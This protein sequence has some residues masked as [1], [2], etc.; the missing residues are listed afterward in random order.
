MLCWYVLAPPVLAQPWWAVPNLLASNH[1]SLR[2][3]RAGPGI[4]TVTGPALLLV[5][6]GIIGAFTGLAAPG[7][8]LVGLAVALAWYIASLRY[9]WTR[10]A[11]LMTDYSPQALLA[12]GY[13]LYGS[14]LGY[15]AMLVRKRFS[16]S[17]Q[18]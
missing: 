10:T 2:V 5:T 13:F 3:L 16:A 1:Y 8:R 15:H 14:A 7:N 11:P 17:S 9:L 18:T 4:A 6:A 12:F